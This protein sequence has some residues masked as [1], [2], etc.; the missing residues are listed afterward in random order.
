MTNLIKLDL[1]DGWKAS[2]R[3]PDSVEPRKL[4]IG[5]FLKSA[6]LSKK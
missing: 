5:L 6:K 1:G 3:D 4:P 2:R